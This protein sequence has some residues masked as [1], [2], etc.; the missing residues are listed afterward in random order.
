M[1]VNDITSS[2]HTGERARGSERQK[3]AVH[4]GF[5]KLCMAAMHVDTAK[6]K[7]PRP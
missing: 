3:A 7:L 6:F 2:V 4:V 1:T 5:W